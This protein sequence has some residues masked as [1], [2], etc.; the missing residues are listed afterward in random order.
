MALSARDAAILDSMVR[1]PRRQELA[2]V[3][4]ET[5]RLIDA[6]GIKPSDA[7]RR[8]VDLDQIAAYTDSV[9][10]ADLIR[11]ERSHWA[12]FE[13]AALH[14]IDAAAKRYDIPT[15]AE[16]ILAQRGGYSS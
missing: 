5:I 13:H 8:I 10:N 2:Q 6:L 7:L 11:L 15:H 9:S 12:A 16:M 4:A 3:R 1:E 14:G